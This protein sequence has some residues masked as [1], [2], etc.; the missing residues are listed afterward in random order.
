MREAVPPDTSFFVSQQVP[1]F[2]LDHR[3][4]CAFEGWFTQ[5]H[6]DYTD[7]L[8]LR[9]P[10]VCRDPSLQGEMAHLSSTVLFPVLMLTSYPSI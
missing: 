5:E 9:P 8:V 2:T 4:R 6:H 7:R 10:L 1:T 3:G